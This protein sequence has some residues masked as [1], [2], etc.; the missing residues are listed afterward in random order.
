MMNRLRPPGKRTKTVLEEETVD[1]SSS[2]LDEDTTTCGG[3]ENEFVSTATV[4]FA[5][6][7]VRMIE[8]GVGS[9]SKDSL[10]L[11]LADTWQVSVRDSSKTDRF[12]VHFNGEV[13]SLK[14]L[15]NGVPQGSVLAVTFFLLAIDSIRQYIDRD[16]FLELFAD[17]ITLGVSDVNVRRARQKLQ[18]VVNAIARWSK[19]TG[20]KVAISKT[21][22]MHVCFKRFHAKKQ[23]TLKLENQEVE[24][25]GSH[26]VLGVWLDY[27]LSFKRHLAKTKAE[28]RERPKI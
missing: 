19:E 4:T 10:K 14:V 6:S 3:N 12:R 5:L 28:C 21:A 20:F 9:S 7:T 13:S 2:F 11:E 17:D 18:T 16:V 22:A 25:V 24:F 15:Q 26:K 23:P 27:R 8:H 1:D